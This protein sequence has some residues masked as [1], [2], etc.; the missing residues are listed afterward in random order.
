MTTYQIN[1]N[2]TTFKCVLVINYLLKIINIL[3]DSNLCY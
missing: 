3:K 2:V 1:Y